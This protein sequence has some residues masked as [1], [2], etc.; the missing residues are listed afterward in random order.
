MRMMMFDRIGGARHVAPL[1]GFTFPLLILPLLLSG[2][3][4]PAPFAAENPWKQIALTGPTMGTSYHIKAV[5]P[6]D[7]EIDQASLQ[8]SIDSELA[9]FNKIFSTYDPESEISRFNAHRS[10]EPFAVSNETVVVAR[11]SRVLFDQSEG[12]FDPTV[13]PLVDL[14]GFGPRGGRTE[15][16]TS[17]EIEEAK[18][19]VGYDRIVINENSLVKTDPSI[20]VNYSAIAKGYGVDLIAGVL[21]EGGF[22][23]Y[24]VEIGGEIVVRGKNLQ[25]RPWS[26]GIDS[27]DQSHGGP[28]TLVETMGL[29]DYAVATSGDYRNAFEWEGVLYSHLI[30]P[31]T[32]WPIPE[33][34]KSVTVIAPTCMLADGA[35]TAIAAMGAEKGLAWAESREDLEVL[36]FVG[37]HEKGYQRMETSG[38]E[39]YFQKKRDERSVPQ[40]VGGN[41]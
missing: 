32:G 38:M 8:S 41:E 40:A 15:P 20:E 5:I 22:T 23:D 10:T 7:R 14:W 28:R 13:G 31:Q 11:E 30:D 17:A 29:S 36:V 3:A 25:R 1:P 16:P 19:R 26:I 39:R 18:A 4:G 24:M 34:V 37:N 27:P 6:S 12:A 35:A 21:D 9:R 33:S 2:C